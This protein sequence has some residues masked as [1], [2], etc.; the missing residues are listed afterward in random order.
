MTTRIGTD[1]YH[2]VSSAFR[3]F[4]PASNKSYP[5]FWRLATWPRWSKLCPIPDLEAPRTKLPLQRCHL[6]QTSECTFHALREQDTLNTFFISGHLHHEIVAVHEQANVFVNMHKQ[7]RIAET[8]DGLVVLQDQRVVRL[9]KR[10]GSHGSGKVGSSEVLPPE[11]N[12]PVHLL[13]IV[14]GEQDTL[15]PCVLA[16]GHYH[17]KVVAVHE[18]ANVFCQHPQTGKDC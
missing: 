9:P 1:L 3:G 13:S 18:Q 6:N 15:E 17:D 10:T 4:A 5:D 16:A 8:L 12:L 7:G 11:W 2:V 14:T